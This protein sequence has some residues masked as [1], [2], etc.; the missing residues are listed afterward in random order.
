[1]MDTVFQPGD[2]VYFLTS[3]KRSVDFGICKDFYCDGIGLELYEMPDFTTVCG[4]PIRNF[5][6]NQPR[7]KLPK[8]WSWDTDLCQIGFDES[9]ASKPKYHGIHMDKPEDLKQAIENGALVKPSSQC[10]HCRVE[11]NITKE[12]YTIVRKFPFGSAPRP[13]LMCVRSD[14]CFR[15]Y[16]EAKAASDAY[17]TEFKRQSELSDY[18]WSVEQIDAALARWKACSGVLDEDVT[19]ARAWLLDQKN[20]EDLVVRLFGGGI[21]FKYERN[22]RWT[23]LDVS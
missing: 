15:T 19:K 1:M 23:Q 14:N 20:V 16:A 6:F 8:G 10:K 2:V 13:D 17:F 18:D 21:Q 5:E 9:E 4:V 3:N 22:R 12:G 11:A 7:R